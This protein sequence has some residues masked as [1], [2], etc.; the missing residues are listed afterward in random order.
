MNMLNSV[1][2]ALGVR[3][4]RTLPPPG[5]KPRY[6][7]KIVKGDVR[8]T[9]QAGLADSTWNWLVDRGWREETYR[10]D[11]RIYRDVPPSLV[12]EFF[13]A[14]DPDERVQ[15]LN[16]AITEAE[17]RPLVTLPPRR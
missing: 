3:K 11:R 8:M 2:K 9:V 13:D 12:A 4:E 5:A 17:V 10:N 15:L 1:R 6:G 7:A 14:T 16:Q